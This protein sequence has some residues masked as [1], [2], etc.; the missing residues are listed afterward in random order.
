MKT[1][2]ISPSE[3]SYVCNHCSYIKKNYD[4]E[5]DSISAG[6][7]QTLDSF[8]KKYFMGDVKKN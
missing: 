7:T 1:F 8:E 5:P 3:L 2:V 6:V 4:I